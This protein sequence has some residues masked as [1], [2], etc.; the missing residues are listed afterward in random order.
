MSRLS[1]Y[2]GYALVTGASSGIGR[3]FA[4]QLASAKVP[5]F[6]VARREER[7]REL[8]EELSTQHSVDV[9]YAALDL[10]EEDCADRLLE[11][12]AEIP[13]GI[14]VNNAG[15]GDG[16]GFETKDP[17]RMA[18]M[19]R[20]NCT[21]PVLLTR[22]F[23][24][25][26]LERGKGA[27][28]M[29]SSALGLVGC[30]F[31]A[32]YGATKAFDVSFGEALWGELENTPID[33]TTVCPALT[34]TEFMIVEGFSENVASKVYQKAD[35]PE[36]IA[37]IALKGLGKSPVVMAKVAKMINALRRVV[38]RGRAVKLVGANMRSFADRR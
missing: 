10:S 21:A 3:E 2:G 23:L 31:E 14:L 38:S 16:G 29:V 5:C 22:A 37:Q 19:I 28:I 34:R 35:S 9:Q 13:I 17:K 4:R 32:V 12:T 18:E 11:A 25:A 24:P 30:P 20:L 33:V 26:M 36:Y 1:E 8:Q 7:L 6:L 27:V 15:F